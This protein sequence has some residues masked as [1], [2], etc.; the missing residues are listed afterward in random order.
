MGRGGDMSYRDHGSRM[1]DADERWPGFD[2]EDGSESLFDEQT[3]D[4]DSPQH[5]GNDDRLEHDE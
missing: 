5:E 2:P 3:W 1:P 4:Y